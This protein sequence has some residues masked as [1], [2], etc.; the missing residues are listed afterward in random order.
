MG[1]A[2]LVAGLS[3]LFV[4]VIGTHPNVRIM[5]IDQKIRLM[6]AEAELAA[7]DAPD[8]TRDLTVD[9]GDLGAPP[10]FTESVPVLQPLW[11]VRT[12]LEPGE[13]CGA[14]YSPD[15]LDLWFQ[16]RNGNEHRI[17]IGGFDADG[18]LRVRTGQD[19]AAEAGP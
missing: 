4:R 11:S 17:H 19:I 8:I 2:I 13:M 14:L 1:A 7:F 6:Q 3:Y 9:G 16:D 5:A 18:S 15:G 10:V 12:D